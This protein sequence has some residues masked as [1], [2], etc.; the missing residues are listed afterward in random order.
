[1][2]ETLK[3]LYDTVQERPRPEDVAALIE[4]TLP[5]SKVEKNKI[6]KATQHSLRAKVSAYSSM[7]ADFTRPVSA[8][9]QV[10]T[11][12]Q[13]FGA[14]RLSAAECLDPARVEQYVRTIGEVIHKT[15]GDYKRLNRAERHALGL[16]KVQRWYNKRFRIL[17]HLEDKIRR[18]TL[19]TRRYEFTRVGKSAMA[20]KIRYEDFT[21]NLTTACFVAYLSARMNKRSQFT[22]TSQERP[23]DDIAEM[24]L[25][26][27]E[28]D[29]GARWDV[30][31]HVWP[32]ERVLIRL[33]DD[34]KGRLLGSWWTLLVDMADLLRDVW[35]ESN[36]NRRTMVVESGNDSSTWNEIALGWN[37]AREHWISLLHSL[38]L[39]S[40]LSAVCPGKVMRL[41]AADV[42]QW[43]LSSGKGLHPDTLVWGD[44][45]SPWEVVRGE[46]ACGSQLV[47]EVCRAHNVEPDKWTGYKKNQRAVPFRPTPELVHGVT[48]SNPVLATVLRKA[49]AFSGKG[50]K[51]EIPDIV[52][53]RDDNGFALQARE[54]EATVRG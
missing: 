38:G 47:E 49:G 14:E 39:E 43:H 29:D 50:L 27:C 4:Q 30:I 6:A 21:A 48:V 22:N 13:V 31:A 28:A 7:A 12:A 23:F 17:C 37:R 15:Y 20:T 41:M 40:M 45:P 52:V 35:R 34:Q 11:A 24:L 19:M 54:S 5:M 42:A 26:K 36:F 2:N 10:C 1:M 8:E 33:T 3:A 16:F 9:K 51:G 46:A 18:L 44:L 25:F 53:D 32:E